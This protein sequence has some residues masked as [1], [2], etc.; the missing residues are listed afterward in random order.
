MPQSAL[1]LPIICLFIANYPRNPGAA[2]NITGAILGS[3]TDP[4]GAAIANAQVDV[5]KLETN[6]R[7]SLGPARRA[8]SRRYICGPVLIGSAPPLPDSRPRFATV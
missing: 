6:Q 1:V 2:Q 4:S 8:C 3:I 5:M 7:T